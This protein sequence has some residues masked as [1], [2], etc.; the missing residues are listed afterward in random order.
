GTGRGRSEPQ[1]NFPHIGSSSGQ[2]NPYFVP[3]IGGIPVPQGA[4]VTPVFTSGLPHELTGWWVY[5]GAAP[6]ASSPGQV[7][8]LFSDAVQR[9][10]L[11]TH[12]ERD[13][14]VF[15]VDTSSSD[16]PRE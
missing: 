12:I 5:Q 4:T 8:R 6:S 13:V 3:A 11:N 14:T 1:S 16:A 7:Q 15:D 10:A 9:T 2:A